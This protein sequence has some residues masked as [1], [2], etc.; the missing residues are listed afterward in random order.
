[1]AEIKIT[2][3]RSAIGRTEKQRRI[4]KSL[5]LRRLHHTVV[6]HDSPTILGMVEKVSHLVKVELA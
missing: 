2:W 6:H 4:I 1:M 3:T 5:G